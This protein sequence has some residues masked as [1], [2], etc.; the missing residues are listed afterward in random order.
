MDFP[1]T[2]K[3]LLKFYAHGFFPMADK[4]DGDGLAIIAPVTRGIL[5]IIDLHIPKRLMKTV[6]QGKF[7]IRVDTA[8]DDVIKACQQARGAKRT[9]SWINPEI[10]KL[11]TALHRMGYAHSVEAWKDGELVGGLYGVSLGQLFCGESMFSKATDASKVALVHL[12]ARLYAGGYQVLDA[13]FENDHLTQFGLQAVPQEDY[14]KMIEPL[15]G[16][17]AGFKGGDEAEI[18]RHYLAARSSV[19][20]CASPVIRPKIEP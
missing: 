7:D 20:A 8:F 2:P 4:S 3:L 13:Q 5:P 1:L 19:G 17:P 6:R 9:D 18:L 11:Y 14:V 16:A 12:C 15:V 10:I